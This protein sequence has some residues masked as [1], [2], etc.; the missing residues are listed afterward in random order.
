MVPTQGDFC[1]HARVHGGQVIVI[2][3]VFF[4]CREALAWMCAPRGQPTVI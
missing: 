1:S 2:T 4:A 3:R